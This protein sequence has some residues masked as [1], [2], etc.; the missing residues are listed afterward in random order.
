MVFGGPD[1]PAAGGLLVLSMLLIEFCLACLWAEKF[2]LASKAREGED[3]SILTICLSSLAACCL[4]GLG[5]FE[6]L[7][8]SCVL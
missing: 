3:L 7:L 8:C 5:Y 1:S 6:M 2:P 4:F